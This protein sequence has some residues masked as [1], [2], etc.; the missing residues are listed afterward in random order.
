[1][2]T[3]VILSKTLMQR[4]GEFCSSVGVELVGQYY[5]Y[6]PMLPRLKHLS[7][8]GLGLEQS[9]LDQHW[10]I[11][12]L[13]E[14]SLEQFP[15][16]QR[17]ITHPEDRLLAPNSV[18]LLG[19]YV[20]TAMLEEMIQRLSHP[21]IAALFPQVLFQDNHKGYVE[22]GQ[23]LARS[24]GYVRD[25]SVT[26]LPY[27]KTIEIRD[28]TGAV[29]VTAIKDLSLIAAIAEKTLVSG[30]RLDN[31]I[32]RLSLANPWSGNGLSCYYDTPR[33]F[34]MCSVVIEP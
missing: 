17:R 4:P 6:R 24:V 9:D 18:R 23:R 20:P 5:Q 31:V 26:I 2:I 19:S 32:V 29:L 27:L 12:S 28:S 13:I 14:M 3:G 16:N 22:G 25:C 11:G 15:E 10:Q 21:S 8:K 7:A 30:S 34:I 33:C 1:M